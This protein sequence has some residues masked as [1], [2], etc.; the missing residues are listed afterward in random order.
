MQQFLPLV[1][2]N[3]MG[4]QVEFFGLVGHG[5][6]PSSVPFVMAPGDA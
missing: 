6:I 3:V 1:F 2:S 5:L 4:T